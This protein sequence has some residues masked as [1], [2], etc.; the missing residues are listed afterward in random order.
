MEAKMCEEEGV[1]IPEEIQ[2]RLA[3]IRERRKSKKNQVEDEDLIFGGDKKMSMKD[4]EKGDYQSDD[5]KKSGKRRDNTRIARNAKA[6][7]DSDYVEQATASVVPQ[8]MKQEKDN[9]DQLLDNSVG[10]DSRKS[11]QLLIVPEINTSKQ[12]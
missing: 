6:N 8:Q 1:E 4:E 5:L 3:R 2:K 9:I 12:V 11:N 10:E 7:K